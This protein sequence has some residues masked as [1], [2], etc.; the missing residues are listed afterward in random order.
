MLEVNK[1]CLIPEEY[2]GTAPSWVEKELPTGWA[3]TVF[4][5]ETMS[6]K[7]EQKASGT[8]KGNESRLEGSEGLFED[9]S[10][11]VQ[12][13]AAK[14]KSSAQVMQNYRIQEI[15]CVLKLRVLP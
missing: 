13:L 8:K 15:T 6:C 5:A 10:C 4:A 14:S 11:E 1:Y 9:Y 7:A 3:R 12:K 2:S